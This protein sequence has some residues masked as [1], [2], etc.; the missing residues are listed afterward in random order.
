MAYQPVNVG[1]APNDGTGDP[2][3]TAFQKI[4]ANFVEVYAGVTTMVT[5]G[6]VTTG[7]WNATPVVTTYGGT[8]LAS[9]TAGDLP[10]YASGT[11]LSKLA[12]GTSTYILTSSGSAPQWSTPATV[13]GNLQG[14]GISSA[15]AEVGF[16][17]MP[18]VSTAISRTTIAADN[19]KHIYVTAS[20]TT[21]TIDSNANVAYQIGATITF[22]ADFAS[23]N[24]TI[25]IT[26][27]TLVL[28]GAGTTGSRTLAAYGMATAVKVTSTRWFINGTG[29]T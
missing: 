16:R 22:V 13:A 5:L 26:S 11:T 9:Y 29:L 23:G 28:A 8:G 2:L 4:N 24:T 10:Y 12:I 3:R 17:G 19:G 6:T 1:S 25:A 20:G 7:V 27:D 21:Q 14:T 15:T 18:Q